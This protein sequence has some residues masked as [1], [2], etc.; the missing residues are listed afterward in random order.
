NVAAVVHQAEG[1]DITIL[2]G[3]E[4]QTREEV[5]VITLFDTLE[6]VGAWQV[7]IYD[8]LPALQNDEAFFGEQIILDEAGDPVGYMD[9]LLITS[10]AFSIEEV[11][12]RV[13]A[14]GGICIP[15]HVDRPMYSIISNLGFVPPGLMVAGLEIS[16]NIRPVEARRRF[17]ELQQYGLVGNSDAHRLRD[18]VGRTMVK[19]AQA[20]VAELALALGGR[21]GREIWVDGISTTRCA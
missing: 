13:A 21:A 6:Q 12:R 17:P 8:S 5:H 4:V 9:R 3:M 2:A 1:T 20:T 18:M 10:S 7:Q 19:V 16:Y 15:A 14:L 11:T